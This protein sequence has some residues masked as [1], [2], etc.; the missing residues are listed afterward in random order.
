MK[1]L[2]TDF[3]ESK[4]HINFNKSLIHI[5]NI[6]KNEVLYLG[7]NKYIKLLEH[8]NSFSIRNFEKKPKIKVC[9]IVNFM[10][11]ILKLS[12][13]IRKI[14]FDFIIITAFNTV[15][16]FFT[17]YLF[18]KKTL[19]IHHNNI[20]DC[21]GSTIY[22]KIKRYML[23]KISNKFLNIYLEK[24]IEEFF[25]KYNLNSIYLPYPVEKSPVVNDKFNLPFEY[26]FAPSSN[27]NIKSFK[28]LYRLIS[29]SNR[30]VKII[31]KEKNDFEKSPNII[32]SKKYFYDYE[33]LLNNCIA[34]FIPIDFKYRVSGVFY[35]SMIRNKKVIF[36][37]CKF[38]EKMK[39][40]YPNSVFILENYDNLDQLYE[41]LYMR[42]N[43]IDLKQF[44]EEH[45]HKKI[46]SI[47]N[48]SLSQK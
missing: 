30:E 48:K 36:T 16:F 35:E 42:K 28:Y 27:L 9:K 15:S 46:Y 4:G 11:K 7:S 20:D 25:D 17:M 40:K 12:K 37:R 26:I 31:C 32:Y 38:A 24:Y 34:V 14:E 13:I 18:N 10:F 29:S 3:L 5:L 6:N 43:N 33:T 21:L 8:N 41:E 2:I 1:I 47:I 44:L 19:L 39:F 22:K 23:L 45:N